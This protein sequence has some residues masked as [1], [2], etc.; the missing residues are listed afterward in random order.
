[1]IA[2]QKR[3]GTT[4]SYDGH[5]YYRSF[6]YCRVFLGILADPRQ[7]P[8]YFHYRR[9]ACRWRLLAEY[10]F[11]EFGIENV[12]NQNRHF[13]L[14]EVGIRNN[15]RRSGGSLLSVGLVASAVFLIVAVGANRKG[16]STRYG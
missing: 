9:D 2:V 1:M 4:S 10:G 11:A 3:P 13:S 6:N 16:L 7:Q 5:H 15:L 14:I 12:V 8:I